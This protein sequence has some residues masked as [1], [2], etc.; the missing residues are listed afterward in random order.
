MKLTGSPIVICELPAP[1]KFFFSNLHVNVTEVKPN[2]VVE[3]SVNVANEGDESGT[4]SIYLYIND[5]AEGSRNVS[6]NGETST[7]ISFIICK[8]VTGTY[9]IDV[10]GLTGNISVYTPPP[11]LPLFQLS[12][13]TLTPTQVKPHEN[14]Y[15]SIAISNLGNASG[16]YS[17][18]VTLDNITIKREDISLEK[19]EVKTNTFIVVSN[20]TGEHSV[21]VN[22]LFM[23]F[24][25]IEPQIV[26]EP[27]SVSEFKE[28]NLVIDPDKIVTGEMITISVSVINV[29]NQSGE[30]NVT[31]KVENNVIDIVCLQLGANELTRV[32]FNTTITEEG[33]H[34]FTVNNLHDSIKVYENTVESETAS[35][36]VR[37][38]FSP[39]LIA[40]I[41]LG[42]ILAYTF[43][44][45]KENS[46]KSGI[47]K[48]TET[49]K[50]FSLW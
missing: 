15:G 21:F 20:L 12:N 19:G 8:N 46:R 29:G 48:N 2:E 43:Q 9:F 11:L 14:V 18:I 31:L 6:L 5:V 36:N 33:V 40:I 3:I 7:N 1:A 35:M 27:P 32:N 16:S 50:S 23:N 22:D 30:Y 24:E 17:I 42:G 47:M 26:E 39:G 34:T 4:C 38:I 44:F 37:N 41:I 13:F 49:V 45:N 10:E 28:Y 25:V